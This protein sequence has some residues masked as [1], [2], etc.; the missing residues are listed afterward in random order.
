MRIGF[1][2]DSYFPRKDGQAYTVR[3]WRRRLEEKGH[4]TYIIYPDS[5]YNAE[6]GVPSY[7]I[8]NPFYKGHKIG[9]PKLKEQLP[10]LDLVHCHS[11]GFNGVRGLIY[12]RRNNVPA[13]YSFHTPLED[14]VPQIIKPGFL[15]RF[16][17]AAYKKYENSLM[18]RFDKVISNT[19]EIRRDVES[20]KIPAGVNLEFFQPQ[21]E[22]FL[23]RKDWKRPLIGYSGRISEE[24]NLKDLIGYLENFEGTLVVVG[25]GRYRKALEQK[26]SANVV[27][28]DFLDREKL[29]EFYS[30]LDVF[31]TASDSDTLSLTTLEASACGTP[32]LAPDLHPFDKTVSGNGELYCFGDEKD[33]RE[34]L[35][36]VLSSDY[37]PREA[38]KDF[39][40]SSSIDRL[41]EVYR[42]VGNEN[43]D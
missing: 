32:V 15:A 41:L 36:R 33:F 9:L 43:G 34:K 19:E 39:S 26:A 24:K 13:I 4:E 14:Y 5:G 42:E 10:E 18:Q 21:E 6:N 16:L 1:F 28:M 37:C 29:P 30:G 25:E 22:G 3:T 11:P 38:V 8:N 20:E 7:S 27:F 12:A 40:V 2:T 35:S 17:Q 23:D 31:A